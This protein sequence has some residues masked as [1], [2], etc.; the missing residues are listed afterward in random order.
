MA[1][2]DGN[3]TCTVSSPMGPQT[4]TL[5]VQSAGDTFTGNASGQ[6]GTIEL[7]NGRVDGETLTWKMGIKVPM[8][9]SLDG[10]A[11]VAGDSLT[12]TVTAGAFGSWPI[13]GQRA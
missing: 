3:W 10:K 8:P 6:L 11:T 9:M 12:G 13:T 1:E 5:A 4:L 7:E 2:V